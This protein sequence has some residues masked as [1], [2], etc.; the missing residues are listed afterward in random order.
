MYA[1]CMLHITIVNAEIA[2]LESPAWHHF[3]D[4]FSNCWK[5]INH[6]IE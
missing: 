1:V 4:Q 3:N 5:F 6:S 2:E